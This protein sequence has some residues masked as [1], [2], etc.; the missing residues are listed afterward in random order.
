MNT[1]LTPLQITVNGNIMLQ[2]CIQKKRICIY[3]K[4]VYIDFKGF[5]NLLNQQYACWW[6]RRLRCLASAEILMATLISCIYLSCLHNWWYNGQVTE[7]LF[8]IVAVSSLSH[9]CHAERWNKNK[10]KQY[11]QNW[12]NCICLWPPNFPLTK[13]PRRTYVPVPCLLANLDRCYVITGM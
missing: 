11:L 4:H 2:N 13:F 9:V 1:T 7:V 6:H 12:L 8:T 10:N 3:S 5:L